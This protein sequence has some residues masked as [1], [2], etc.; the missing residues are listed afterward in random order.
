VL[1][2]GG[3]VEGKWSGSGLTRGIIV[4][5][6]SGHGEMGRTGR[7]DLDGVPRDGAFGLFLFEGEV[8]A[9]VDGGNRGMGIPL[10]DEAFGKAGVDGNGGFLW[11]I[12]IENR[13]FHADGAAKAAFEIGVPEMLDKGREIRGAGERKPVHGDAV[14]AGDGGKGAPLV[15]GHVG[16]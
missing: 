12:E 9:R 11:G 14:G 2:A 13:G 1:R 6:G 10:G 4:V 5:G 8:A 15:D 7:L 3:G 16:F